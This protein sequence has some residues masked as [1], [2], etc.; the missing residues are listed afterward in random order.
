MLES[1]STKAGVESNFDDIKIFSRKTHFTPALIT[2]KLRSGTVFRKHKYNVQKDF[3]HYCE[4]RS[5]IDLPY[6]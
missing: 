6:L 5:K 1:P 2:Q 3:A 4:G